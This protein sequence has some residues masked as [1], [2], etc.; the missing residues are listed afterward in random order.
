MWGNNGEGG[1][2]DHTP[3]S[4]QEGRINEAFRTEGAYAEDNPHFVQ[5][6]FC[7]SPPP[8]ISWHL[9]PSLSPPFPSKLSLTHRKTAF[10]P[11]GQCYRR[12]KC[13]QEIHEEVNTLIR[14]PMWISRSRGEG[15]ARG[16]AAGPG[17]ETN[18]KAHGGQPMNEGQRERS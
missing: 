11:C 6:D 1:R 9:S 7:S 14:S 16:Q 8:A 12:D 2:R 13:A 10:L 18:G 4:S 5:L 17:R 3:S 15:R